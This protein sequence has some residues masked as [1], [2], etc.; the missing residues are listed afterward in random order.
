M[1]KLLS[2]AVVAVV[3]AMVA[4][5]AM[6]SWP[7]NGCG[8]ND[9][10]REPVS[11]STS[12]WNT[13]K[14][15][16]VPVSLSNTG[17]NKQND[18]LNVG[19]NANFSKTDVVSKQTMNTGKSKAASSSYVEVLKPANL[20]GCPMDVSDC[21][22]NELP[23]QTFKQ[24]NRVNVLSV[25]IAL[26]NSGLNTQYGK[27]YAGNGQPCMSMTDL[28][29]AQTMKTGASFAQAQ[30]WVVVNGRAVSTTTAN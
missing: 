2:F 1:K 9:C 3:F 12:S 16:S 29:D 28:N 30:S 7:Y 10:N 20:C 11:V 24:S 15:V 23:N 27:V 19:N 18:V 22:C 8:G 21:K 14:V 5:P 13:T 6:A 25:P 4:A 26:S 17:L